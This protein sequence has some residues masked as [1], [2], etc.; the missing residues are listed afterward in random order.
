MFLSSEQAAESAAANFEI[1]VAPLDDALRLGT[2]KRTGLLDS[3]SESVF[4]RLVQLAARIVGAPVSLVSLVDDHRQFFKAQCGLPAPLDEER[5]T[6]LSHSFCQ[7]VVKSTAPLIVTNSRED[8]RVIGNLAIRDMNVTAYLGIPLVAPDGHVLGSFC[9]ID[10]EPREWSESDIETMTDL[11]FAVQ[12]EIALRLAIEQSERDAETRDML[13]GELNHRVKNLFAMVGG[14]INLTARTAAGPQ[15]MAE[16]LTGRIK[17]L[18]RAHN[19]VRPMIDDIA[20]DEAKG[21]LDALSEAILAPHRHAGKLTISGDPLPLSTDSAAHLSLVLHEL[22]TNMVKYG[23]FSK[24]G[25]SVSIQWRVE[26]QDGTQWLH[27]E[28]TEQNEALAITEP[29]HEQSG[30]GS[31]L[32]QSAVRLQLGGEMETKWKPHGVAIT[33]RIPVDRISP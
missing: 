20:Q 27:L 8:E 19:L 3:P 21:G 10:V 17:A 32:I 6:P 4:D 28:W 18:A 24:D 2:L 25:G 1:K 11:A 15:E 16:S 33:L 30:F 29:E 12:S 9:V 31:R 14:M 13:I 26:D 5:E 23:A 22:A 7:Y